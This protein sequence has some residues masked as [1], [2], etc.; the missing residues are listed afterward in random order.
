MVGVSTVISA[1]PPNTLLVGSSGSRKEF[2]PLNE[3]K[4]EFG[5]V[6]NSFWPEDAEAAAAANPPLF[7]KDAN[8]PLAGMEPIAG[9]V[10]E[11]AV[12]GLPHSEAFC[13]GTAEL[14]K[15]AVWPKA[16]AAPGD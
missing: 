8:P 10:L 7:T 5:L 6:S 14:P 15:V 13:P 12:L 11:V 16:G 3:D 4:P 1:L 9:V 2:E